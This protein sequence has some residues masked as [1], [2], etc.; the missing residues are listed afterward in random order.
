MEL[1]CHAARIVFRR[2]SATGPSARS[3]AGPAPLASTRAPGVRG[4]RRHRPVARDL[5]RPSRDHGIDFSP[6]MLAKA[7]KGVAEA[8]LRQVVSLRQMDARCL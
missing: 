1:R 8:G 6:E 3:P 2:R 7:V 5:C 4:W